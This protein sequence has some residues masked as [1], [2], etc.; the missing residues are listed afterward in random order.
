MLLICRT[1][2]RYDPR[3]S[4]EFG[5][6]MAAAVAAHPASVAVRGVQCLGGC[7]EDGVAAVDGPGKARVRFTGLDAGH[8]E[9]VVEAAAAHDACPTGVP[10]D[11]EV[12]AELAGRISAVTLKRGP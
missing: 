7:P 5:R 6:A 10:D 12:P 2:P 8:A 3:T 4:G 1:C 11:W 9:A